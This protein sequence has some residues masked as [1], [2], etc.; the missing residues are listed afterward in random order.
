MLQGMSPICNVSF[1][2]SSSLKMG[3]YAYTSII[4]CPDGT[5]RCGA[6][7]SRESCWKPVIPF[8]ILAASRQWGCSS[9]RTLVWVSDS[10]RVVL[11]DISLMMKG[12]LW[13]AHLFIGSTAFT[14]VKHPSYLSECNIKSRLSCIN[15]QQLAAISVLKWIRLTLAK[16]LYLTS[17]N[18]PDGAPGSLT[19][20]G[21]GMSWRLSCKIILR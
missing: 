7:W 12:K 10:S 18:S 9:P 4:L 3:Y 1:Q 11:L 19:W 17:S 16:Y 2:G 15:I 13:I 20:F 21:L 5:W 6:H 14:K 8:G